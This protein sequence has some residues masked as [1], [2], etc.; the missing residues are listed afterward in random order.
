L[1]TKLEINLIGGAQVANAIMQQGI[2]THLIV[3]TLL[4]LCGHCRYVA[5]GSGTLYRIADISLQEQWMSRI[6]GESYFNPAQPRQVSR[7]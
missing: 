2:L 7:C 6:R 1:Q 4:K 5:A 3:P